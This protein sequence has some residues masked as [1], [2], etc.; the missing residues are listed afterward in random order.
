MWNIDR[1]KLTAD[2]KSRPMRNIKILILPLLIFTLCCGGP[3]KISKSPGAAKP[4]KD[5]IFYP[6]LPDTPRFQYLTT[7]STSD[8][9]K[10]RKSK[11]FNFIAGA[12]QEKPLVIKKAYGV[13]IYDGVIYVCDFGSGAVVALD[14]KNRKFDYIGISGS[15]K[16][17]KPINL[18]I[19]KESKILYVADMGRKQV[20][21]YDLVS[22][23]PLKFYG[24]K[25]QFDPSDVDIHEEKIFICDVKAHQIHVLDR[26]TSKTLYKIGKAGSAE[27][28]FFHPT[29]IC[30]KNDRLYVSDT[31]NFRIQVFDLRG[32]FLDTFGKVGKR[33]GN[34][35]R[36]K[37]IAVDNEGRI[38]VVDAAF[39]NVQ[40]FNHEF[41]LLLFMLR[42]GGE[43][44]NI[45]LP[46][47]IAID[48]D[49]IEYFRQY[50]SPDFKAEYLLVVTSQFGLNK[51]NVYAFGSYQKEQ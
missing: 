15:G 29:N 28:E 20:V 46:A 6:P 3:Q 14:L 35:S 1:F 11:F 8:D 51:V 41:K 12:E 16:L 40:V 50:L 33:P 17:L 21:C 19:D 23:K 43:K 38:Y 24:V 10:K 22:G 5:Y 31:T 36:S 37:G 7:F 44:H 42:S 34:F 48:Y 18:K 25:G 39:E 26:E 9:I 4:G 32:K 49:N 27:G 47:G 2:A 30:I 13:D 45:Y